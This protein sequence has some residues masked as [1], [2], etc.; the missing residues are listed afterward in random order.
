MTYSLANQQ[1]AWL[2][3]GH[4]SNQNR[5]YIMAREVI[6][7]GTGEAVFTLTA[8]QRAWTNKPWTIVLFLKKIPKGEIMDKTDHYIQH[9]VLGKN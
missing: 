3:C 7:K 5:T 8:T 2:E 9:P 1:S 4:R 6:Q